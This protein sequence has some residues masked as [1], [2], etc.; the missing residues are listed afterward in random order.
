M[1]EHLSVIEKHDALFLLKN[2][3][4]IPKLT[5]V[6]H[7]VPC[8]IKSSILNS[9][10]LVIKEALQTILNTNCSDDSCWQQCT[11]PIKQGGLGVR[12]ASEVAL[13]AYLS[14]VSASR[15]VTFSLLKEEIQQES[16]HFYNQGCV[17]WKTILGVTE[18]PMNPMFQ[19]SCDK[20]LCQKTT[21]NLA[22]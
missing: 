8:F 11:L 18:I 6:L 3:F 12:F 1:A 19:S 15:G 14:S 16:N 2:C 20:P 9:Y 10:D 21:R 22:K 5:Y 13:P 17:E 7:T 4:A